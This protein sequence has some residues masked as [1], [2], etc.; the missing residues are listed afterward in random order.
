MA[1]KTPIVGTP[2]AIEGIDAQDG[3]DVFIAN[4][5]EALAKKTDQILKNSQ[6]GTNLADSAYRLVSQKYNW[7][8]ISAKLDK[9]YQEVGS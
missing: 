9:V 8:Q 4:S 1:T 5:A 3:K 6:I 2:L 7:R